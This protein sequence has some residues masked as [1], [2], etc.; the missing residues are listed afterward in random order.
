MATESTSIARV[1]DDPSLELIK[2]ETV[3]DSRRLWPQQLADQLGEEE[4]RAKRE[5][6]KKDCKI[7]EEQKKMCKLAAAMDQLAQVQQQIL[8]QNT[9]QRTRIDLAIYQEG[10]DIECF[11]ENFDDT[12]TSYSAIWVGGMSDTKAS[13]YTKGL[14]QALLTQKWVWKSEKYYRPGSMC[15]WRRK[16]AESEE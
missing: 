3:S 15:I 4:C 8:Q 11:P 12:V 5:K 7:R 1:N 6:E 16:Q 10:E 2:G 14:V 13:R 9:S